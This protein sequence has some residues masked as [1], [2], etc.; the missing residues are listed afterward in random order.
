MSFEIRPAQ[1][2]DVP[3]ILEL[4]RALALY[5]NALDQ[6][7]ASAEDLLRDGFGERPLFEVLLAFEHSKPVGFA[8]YFF[9]YSTWQGRRGLYLEDLFVIPEARKNGYGLALL[10]A[11][12]ARAQETGCG[13]FQLQCLDWNKPAL[14]FYEALGFKLTREWLPLRIETQD[15][16]KSL[17]GQK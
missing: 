12:A 6:A 16:I 14:D 8:F 15:G 1:A 7:Q 11:V 3:T 5:E 10:R 2:S 9:N 4:I 13:R 17:A